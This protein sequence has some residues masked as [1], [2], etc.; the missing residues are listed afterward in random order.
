MLQG[1]HLSSALVAS[2]S[3]S[4]TPAIKAEYSSEVGVGAGEEQHPDSQ[5]ASLGM[6]LL[7]PSCGKAIGPQSSQH[8][9]DQGPGLL[10]TFNGPT[11]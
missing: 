11:S 6:E 10:L 4:D 2:F 3:L 9:P 1:A 5:L 7:L 8:A